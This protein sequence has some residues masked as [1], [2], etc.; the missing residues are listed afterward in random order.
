[1]LE[2]ELELE[3]EYIWEKLSWLRCKSD[4]IELNNIGSGGSGGDDDDDDS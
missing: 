3:L 2:L 4:D 1:M